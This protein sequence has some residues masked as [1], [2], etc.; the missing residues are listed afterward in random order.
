[1]A[2]TDQRRSLNSL[3]LLLLLATTVVPGI[4]TADTLIIL[5]Q[6]VNRLFD[7]IDDGNKEKRLSQ[8]AF[9]SRVTQAANRFATEFGAPHIIALQE[10]ENARVLAA[11]ADELKQLH[12]VSYQHRLLPGHDPSS[13]NLGFLV[14]TEIEI[15]N[16]EQL[17]RHRR[18]K[19]SDAP[20]FTRP[21]LK[22]EACYRSDCLV[23]VNLHLRSMRGLNNPNK[24]SRVLAKRRQ[25]AEAIARWTDRFQE[26]RQ[27]A[28]LLLL[29]DFNA[30]TPADDH[31][32][33]AGIIRGN[34]DNG[35]RRQTASDLLDPDLIDLSRLVSPSERYSYRFKNQPQ[36]LDYL[37]ATE[38][39]AKRARH[40]R[41]SDID[42]SFSDHAGVVASFDW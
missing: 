36:L 3:T 13:I 32:D 31:L 21:P 8:S 25:Q 20:L 15:R 39:L 24:R 37:Y 40:V 22:L 11:I 6:N 4:A 7:H 1:M 27:E 33:V 14:R 18:V 12:G 16:I 34:P 38:A 28:Q 35:G 17:F 2:S 41:Y 23:M 9:R 42:R 30:L 29:G 5:S 19:S 26:R 10:V